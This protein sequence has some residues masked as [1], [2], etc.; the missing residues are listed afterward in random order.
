M[1]AE[2][3]ISGGFS[4]RIEHCQRLDISDYLQWSELLN[5]GRELNHPSPATGILDLRGLLVFSDSRGQKYMHLG[6]YL[7][8]GTT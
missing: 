5:P 3:M 2:E 7:N 8:G 6:W 4:D 1:V